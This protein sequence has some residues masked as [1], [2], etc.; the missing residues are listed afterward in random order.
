MRKSA[1]TRRLALFLLLIVGP[2]A[3]ALAQGAVVKSAEAP[4]AAA[5]LRAVRRIVVL[6]SGSDAAR[7]KVMEDALTLE[8]MKHGIECVARSRVETLIAQKLSEGARPTSPRDAKEAADPKSEPPRAPV[9]PVGAVQVARAA[10]AQLVLVGTM[11]EDR[12]AIV[13]PNRQGAP[14]LVPQPVMVVTASFQIIDVETDTILMVVVA[15]WEAGKSIL[16]AT[17]D[18]IKPLKDAGKR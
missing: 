8:L 14:E 6:Y 1:A 17:T 16:D 5:K 3:A 12:A 7:T 13:K 9:E 10:G 18:L 2:S 4:G 15:E 11:F